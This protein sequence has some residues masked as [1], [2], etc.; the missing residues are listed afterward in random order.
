MCSDR[1][2]VPFR[3]C[4]ILRPGPVR[5][6]PRARRRS[7]LLLFVER[8]EEAGPRGRGDCCAFRTLPGERTE[9][10]ISGY[11]GLFSPSTVVGAPAGVR[12][13]GPARSDRSRPAGGKLLDA[14]PAAPVRLAGGTGAAGRRRPPRPRRLRG[15]AGGA[16]RAGVPS[17]WCVARRLSAAAPRNTGATPGGGPR[18]ERP[19]PRRPRRPD[20]PTPRR[21]PGPTRRRRRP[22]AAEPT[23]VI[24]SLHGAGQE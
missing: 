6:E 20:V 19:D 18:Q 14:R 22:R 3:V 17:V 8:V 11:R 10:Q 15:P 1:A 23:P 5:K 21:R 7:R 12:C 16:S 13:G 2:R 9:V 24:T 4:V